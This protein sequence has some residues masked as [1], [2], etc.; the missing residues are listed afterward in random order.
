MSAKKMLS[1]HKLDL[2]SV[3]STSE[4]LMKNVEAVLGAVTHLPISF[5]KPNMFFT[6]ARDDDL[7]LFTNGQFPKTNIPGKSHP[8]YS[9]RKLPQGVGFTVCPCSSKRP[10]SRGAFRY[11]RKGCQLGHTGHV[12]DRDSYLIERSRFN[13]PRSIAYELRFRGEVREECLEPWNR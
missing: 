4:T 12:M 7:S 10:F 3:S 9:L 2:W 6:G 1:C 8:V 5:W 13:V 11:I